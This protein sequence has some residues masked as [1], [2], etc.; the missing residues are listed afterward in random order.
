MAVSLEPWAASYNRPSASRLGAGDLRVGGDQGKRPAFGRVTLTP[1]S[2]V[3]EQLH[4]DI[5]V[6]LTRRE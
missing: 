1:R 4:Y 5:A 3:A 6:L 2:G